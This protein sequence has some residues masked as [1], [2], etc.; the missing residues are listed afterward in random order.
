MINVARDEQVYLGSC[1]RFVSEADESV[2]L[3]LY[4]F[5][6]CSRVIIGFYGWDLLCV[7]DAWLSVGRGLVL[8]SAGGWLGMTSAISQ[9]LELIVLATADPRQLQPQIITMEITDTTS[10]EQ[11]EQEDSC[12]A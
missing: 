3:G 9:K 6:Q 10:S 11:A 8:G 4:T 12:V 5:T 1:C 7:L 2:T